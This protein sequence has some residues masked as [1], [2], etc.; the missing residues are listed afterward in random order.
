MADNVIKMEE[1]FN[2]RVE[3]IKQD[4]TELLKET[5]GNPMEQLNKVI[6]E[7]DSLKIIAQLL[8]LPDKEFSVVSEIMLNQLE[9]SL[10]K[11]GMNILLAQTLNAQGTKIEDLVFSMDQFYDNIDRNPE[12]AGLSSMKK[13]FLKR[14][15][16][17]IVNSISEVEGISKKIIQVP[18]ELI[19]ED[20]KIPVYAN[21]TDAGMD[22][23]AIEDIDI[24][25]GETVI[26]KTGI[27]VAV[28]QGYELQVRPKS[29]R[30][31]KS[32][33]RV[34]N[35][36]GTIDSGYRDEVGIILENIEPKII[37]ITYDFENG[38]P[39]ITSILHGSSIHIGKG[40]KVAQLV[41]SE[42]PHAAFKEVKNIQEIE[43]NRGGGFGSTGLK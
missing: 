37:D 18:I 33:L 42:V 1:N 10:T 9:R 21:S 8:T 7:E 38:K 20:A 14:M 26:M 35:T 28:P 13:S 27:K 16:T 34:A 32:K 25:P 4:Q 2:K 23:Y 29:G 17:T 40:E 36:P 43:G 39:V 15:F 11:G 5:V 30:S 22:V 41:L 24:N 12:L 19:H 31:A 6:Q 3:E